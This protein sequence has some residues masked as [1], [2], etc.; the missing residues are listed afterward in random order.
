MSPARRNWLLAAI[1][2]LLVVV[3]LV[4]RGW[5]AEGTE[6]GGA[7]MQGVAA[8]EELA[9]EDFVPWF[10]PI[11]S[12]E[13]LERYYFGLQALLGTL[14][15][16]GIV[17]WI[18][19][20]SRARHGMAGAADLAVAGVLCAVGVV[21]AIGLLFVETEFGELQATIS[22]SQGIGLGLLAFFIGYPLGR[23]AGAAVNAS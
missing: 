20:R 16:A 3:P 9:G 12:P 4:Y 14:L 6:W 5:I 1:V 10:N 22:A 7:D 17:G 11:Y 18:L 2:I 21:L 23:R 8:V 19:G 13:D 15:V